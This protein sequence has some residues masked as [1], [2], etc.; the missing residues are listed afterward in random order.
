M[1]EEC[2]IDTTSRCSISEHFSY[3]SVS[4]KYNGQFAACEYNQRS[5]KLH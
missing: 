2:Q 5:L 3:A 1:I 4:S